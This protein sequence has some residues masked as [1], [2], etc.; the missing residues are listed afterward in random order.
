MRIS[1]LLVFCIFS[2]AAVHATQTCTPDSILAST[3]DSQLLD[4]GDGTVTDSK[5]GLMWKQCLEGVGG[6]LCD[7]GL[8]SN[9]TWQEALKQPIIVNSGGGFAGYTDWRLPNIRELVSIVEEQCYNPAINMNRFPNTPNSY[10]WS[11]SPYADSQDL[12]WHVLSSYG[13]SYYSNR[14]S[15]FSVRLV[16]GGN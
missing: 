10:V 4:N 1:L 15:S 9:F 13:G 2:A 12:A 7:A 5:T 3:S 6:A 11:G 8:P 16:R 14:I